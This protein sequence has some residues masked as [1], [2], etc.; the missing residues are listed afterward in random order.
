MAVSE[1][2]MAVRCAGE[3]SDES[4]LPKT[5]LQFPTARGLCGPV[6]RARQSRSLAIYSS[7]VVLAIGLITVSS[8]PSVEALALGLIVPGGGFLIWASPGNPMQVLAI[9]FFA[10]SLLVF[11]VSVAIWFATG[12][13]LIPMVVWLAAGLAAA[14][15]GAV[16][17][18]WA[19]ESTWQP[20]LHVV[21]LSSVFVL[22]LA[23]GT[24]VYAGRRGL[25]RRARLNAYL[26]SPEAESVAAG[27]TH[28]PI[29]DELSKEDLQLMRLLLDRALQPV[30]AFE[31]FQWIDQFQTAAVRYQLNF[32]SYALSIAQAVHLPA[33][34]GYFYT[35]QANLAAKQQ[36]HRVW[37]YWKLENMWE[38]LCVGADPV[39][40][41]NIMF[42]G[43]LVA[44][45]AFD[46]GAT[47][48]RKYKSPGSLVFEH[49]S[50]ERFAYSMPALIDILLRGYREA[51]FGLLACEPNWIYPLCNAISASAI[52]AYDGANGTVYWDEIE[53]SF[54]QSLETEFITTGGQLIPFRSSRTGIAAPPIGGV[55]MQAFPCLFLNALLPD[56]AQRQWLVLRHDLSGRNWRRAL[57]PVDVGNYRFSRASSY[58]ATAAAAVELGDSDVAKRLLQFLHEEC[59]L[60]VSGNVAHRSNASLWAHAVELIARCGRPGALRS[61]VTEPRKSPASGPFIK[62]AGYPDV[63]VAK[64]INASESLLA[65][66][67]AGERSGFKALTIG[68][69][70]PDQD[71]IAAT[72]TE[73]RFR[74]DAA[75]EARLSA[76]PKMN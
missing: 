18:V 69:L 24:A 1:A 3:S 31:G 33:F 43:F 55:A 5:G 76:R 51:E 62:D 15:S 65:I 34:Q 23:Y 68:G 49:P 71:Y 21:P 64:A 67:Y 39:P 47:G 27:K 58:A 37:R 56:I 41:D 72:G 8:R 57:W 66:L 9:S 26:S 38:N 25:F 63:L 14:G 12:N 73:H 36:D 28:D 61:L 4:V 74:A 6:T 46:W 29:S 32:T 50:G 16:G 44:Q 60:R 48:T 45:I 20:A 54:R 70:A 10:V 42:T 13:I 30:E 75:G 19:S 17:W 11:L 2:Q 35:A 59:L 40:R 52:R 53:D 7:V 22:G